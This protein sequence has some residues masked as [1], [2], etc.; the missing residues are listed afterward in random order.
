M[1]NIRSITPNLQQAWLEGRAIVWFKLYGSAR[2]TLDDWYNIVTETVKEWDP[3]NP[4]LII[5]DMRNSAITTHG[6]NRAK[7]FAE[8]IAD[9]HGRVAF[10]IKEEF[11]AP[12]LNMFINRRL[13]DETS[14][15]EYRDFIDMDEAV[16]WLSELAH[17]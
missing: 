1:E 14:N 3:S 12:M 6:Q 4:L 5:N 10:V 7:E 11:L 17:V 15:V 8:Q 13:Q 2:D 16:Q 9:H